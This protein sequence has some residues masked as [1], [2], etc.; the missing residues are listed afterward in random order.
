MSPIGNAWSRACFDGEFYRSARPF[1]DDMPIV[2]LVFVE[3]RDHNTGADDPSRLGGGETD[4]HLIYEG[5]SRVDTDAVLSGAT[6]AQAENIVF[7]VWHPELVSL[8]LQRARSR[9]PAQVIVCG[10][11]APPLERGLM[12]QEPTLS[13]FLVTTSGVAA[14]LRLQVAGR[15][16]ITVIDGGQPLSMSHALRA[17]KARGILTVSAVGG[18][19]TATALLDER[20][21]QDLYLT[22]SPKDGGEPDTPM[23]R[24]RLDV[25]T[26]LIKDGT[27]VE[28][29]VRFVHS[30][31]R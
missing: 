1:D 18:R 13:V 23:Y 19:R 7:S 25:V 8:R 10:R 22:T 26:V 29:G 27:G 15:P 4:T 3:S 21:V 6:T 2:N 17:L 14:S 12:F 31:V 9:H 5:L 24:R 16:W 20:L 11:S 30:V 28:K